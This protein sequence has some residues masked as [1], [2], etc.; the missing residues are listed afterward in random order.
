MSGPLR[1]ERIMN[2]NITLE[3]LCSAYRAG[4][5]SQV[6]VSCQ[7]LLAWMLNHDISGT[8]DITDQQLTILLI[9]SSGHAE[10][11]LNKEG[12]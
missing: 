3:C 6:D 5:W 11:R 10:R 4:N 7:L 9:M 8:L 12:T 1:E 2:P